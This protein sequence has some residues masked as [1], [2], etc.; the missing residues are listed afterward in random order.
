MKTFVPWLLATFLILAV[1]GQTAPQPGPEHQ[2]LHVWTGEWKY[3]GTAHA[4]PLGKGGPFAGVQ[5][6]R[7]ILN[8]FFVELR[9]NDKGDFGDEKGVVGEGLD[10]YGYDPVAKAYTV[11][12]F[13][14]EGARSVGTL[15]VEGNT[16]RQTS[17]RTGSDGKIHQGR[18]VMVFS[19]DGR[20]ISVKSELRTAEGKWVPLWDLVMKKVG[21]AR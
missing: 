20:E 11:T 7:T 8:G 2:K 15:E 21:E 4:N 1:Q 17:T 9:W 18:Y 19:K 10:I 13:D 12:S 5:T 16:W 6:G 14:R 3:E